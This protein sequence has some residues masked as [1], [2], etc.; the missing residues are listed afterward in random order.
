MKSN[1]Q[2]M[3][4]AIQKKHVCKKCTFES[5]MQIVPII[6]W[7]INVQNVNVLTEIMNELQ[8]YHIQQYLLFHLLVYYIKPTSR[9]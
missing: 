3:Q 4:I 1:V 6:I 2:K 9:L 8:C 5:F 7:N